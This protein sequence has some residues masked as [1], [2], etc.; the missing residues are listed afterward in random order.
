MEEN[1]YLR[2]GENNSSN[3]SQE[4]RSSF[5]SLFSFRGRIRRSQYWLINICSALLLLPSQGD[6]ASGI[7]II[8]TLIIIIPVIWVGIA[9]SVKR[10]HDFGLCGWWAILSIIPI[11]NLVL[12]VGLAFFKGEKQDNKYGP[13]PY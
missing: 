2:D 10:L 12:G 6:N 5:S 7:I 1:Q 9:T 4:N 3:I 11:L 8:L 13:N